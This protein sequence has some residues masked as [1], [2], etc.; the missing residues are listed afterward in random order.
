MSRREDGTW[1]IIGA[2]VIVCSIKTAL[3]QG[4]Y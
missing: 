1:Q 4:I 2:F 3:L